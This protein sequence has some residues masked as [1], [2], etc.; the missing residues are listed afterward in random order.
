MWFSAQDLTS[1]VGGL[2]LYLAAIRACGHLAHVSVSQVPTVPFALAALGVSSSYVV[3]ALVWFRTQGFIAGCRRMPLSLLGSDP[4]AVFQTLVLS[5]KLIQQLVL[6]GWAAHILGG[7]LTDAPTIYA[8]L[9]PVV[10]AFAKDTPRVVVGMLL[11]LAG[12]TLNA[13]IYK[14]IG[15]NGVY[16]G[17]K[18]GAQVPWVTGFPFNLGYRHPQYVGGTLSQCA[19]FAVLSSPETQTAGLLPLLGWWTFNYAMVSWM[20]A[21][22]GDNDGKEQG[23]GE[24]KRD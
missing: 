20:E 4:I 7:D 15:K 10:I 23:A 9:K 17:F 8:V 3:Y 22:F 6:L 19:L 16:Y 18:L 2:S 21:S 24:K 11:L 14:A 5:F 1:L 12:Q 13:G